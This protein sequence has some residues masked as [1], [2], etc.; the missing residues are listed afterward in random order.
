MIYLVGFLVICS[1]VLLLFLIL[2]FIVPELIY[3]VRGALIQVRSSKTFLDYDANRFVRREAFPD[4]LV[5]DLRYETSLYDE[6]YVFKRLDKIKEQYR[7]LTMSPPSFFKRERKPQV[8]IGELA[9]LV[10]NLGRHVTPEKK[11]RY[12]IVDAPSLL[13]FIG[14]EI[15]KKNG[16]PS[17]K[18]MEEVEAWLAANPISI[19]QVIEILIASVHSLAYRKQ[20]QDEEQKQRSAADEKSHGLEDEEREVAGSILY[21]TYEDESPPI[22]TVQHTGDTLASE[23]IVATRGQSSDTSKIRVFISYSHQD[24]NYLEQTSL[25]GALKGLGREGVEFWSDQAITLGNK[26][27]EE[28]KTRISQSHIALVLISQAFLDSAYCQNVE[29]SGFLEE[30]ERRGLVIMPIM[31]SK[32]EWDRHDWLRM[33]QYLPSDN[34]T[35]EGDFTA[36]GKRKNLFHDIRQHLRRQIEKIRDVSS[37]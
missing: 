9:D 2:R 3:I 15:R 23:P 21:Q 29:I 4:L 7:V 12:S 16:Q 36:L 14:N 6:Q 24:K 28:I 32:C 5:E 8:L 20:V 19:E 1:A 10:G 25:L 13:T 26:W 33:R 30:A 18:N 22:E 37:A 34:K 31:L 11:F 17:L 27:D 35:V